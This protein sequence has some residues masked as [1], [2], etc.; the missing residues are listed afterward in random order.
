MPGVGIVVVSHSRA[1]AEAAVALAREMV[2]GSDVR[3]QVAAGL[4]ETTFGTDA[5]AIAE[6]ITA[7]DGPAGVVVLMDLGSAVL[8]AEL[9][10]ELIEPEIADR[11]TLCPAP[12][13]EGLVV[14]AVSA[15][16][17]ATRA[18]VAAEATD[19]LAGK[20]S[21]L[22][23]GAPTTHASGDLGRK[24]TA[25]ADSRAGPVETAVF[26]VTNEHGLHARPAARLVGDMRTYDADVRL[27]NRT[28]GVG[29]VSATSLSR[30]A[31]LG[32]IKGHEVE[33]TASGPQ[34]Q[35]AVAALVALAAREFDESVAPVSATPAAGLSARR[36]GPYGA[37]PGIA[38]G[39]ARHLS[40]AP[41]EVTDA[42][43]DD[44]AADQRA[45][46]RALGAVRREITAVRDRTARESTA[47]EAAIFDAHL[48]LLDDDDIVGAARSAI[49]A[50]IAAAPAWA[51]A[52]ERVES[53]FESVDD[54]YLRARGADV[55]AVG[56]QVLRRLLGTEQALVSD[57]GILV[58]SDLTPAEAALLDKSVVLGA[59]LAS[60]SPTAHSAILARSR[61]IATIVGA[62]DA[63]LD[64][65][66]G[67]LIAMDGATGELE[68]D[69]AP[70][71]VAVMTDRADSERVARSRAL[72]A[73][74]GHAVTRND[75]RIDVG[76]NVGSAAETVAAIAQGADLIGLV[77]T[78]FLFLD[79][80]SPPD[81]DEQIATYRAIASAADGRR[82]TLRTLDVGGDKPLRYLPQ[83][84]E[85]NPFLGVRGI[86]LALSHPELLRDQL[87]AIVAVA[88][89]SPV[90][91]M[92]P[93]VA[94]LAE[95]RS[96]RAALDA[97]I[98]AAGGREPDGLQVGV[99]V[100]VPSLAL[101]AGAIAPYVDFFSIGTNDLTQYTMAAERG[102]AAV[103]ELSDPLDPGVLRL[104]ND[105]CEAAA[106]RVLVVVCGEL[107]GDP[108][109]VDLLV[110]MGVRELSVAGPS[111]PMI[112]EAV[113][114]ADTVSGRPLVAA[115]L[116]APDADAV[117]AMLTN[118]ESAGGVAGLALDR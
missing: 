8:S 98:A 55:R 34:A 16:G 44:P 109:A 86:R 64:I 5:V 28:T 22:Q 105:V 43:T 103:A 65:P 73:A 75:V 2:Q 33:V 79:R 17:G 67:T 12:L 6:A 81:V 111:V 89:E 62:G 69:P 70:D 108:L 107:A 68:V 4:D 1:L 60:G 88:H 110:A 93:M 39:P 66:E 61:G 18:E 25:D 54:E 101:K 83:A 7:A 94:T 113:R 19:A 31:T 50:G 24:F 116:A 99:M 41:L 48:L 72:A 37:S 30:V 112:K 91:V 90:S 32:V 77:R 23:P 10:L 53:A 74:S 95:L 26:S 47:A 29:P 45:L 84:V 106:E 100:E 3:I 46:D 63:V 118:A 51:T 14:A 52:V 35:Q 114:R 57:V 82:I 71:L 92:F 49:A 42:R 87:T 9:A 20:E 85:I 56:D 38:I 102:N 11:V 115:A 97:A 27:S 76:A 104:I 36:G 13:V 21:Q 78:E 96:A 117:R 40:S 58:A 15:G 59:V 80:Q